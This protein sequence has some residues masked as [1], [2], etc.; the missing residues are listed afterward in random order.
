MSLGTEF[1]V[2]STGNLYT[3]IDAFNSTLPDNGAL[4]PPGSRWTLPINLANA[5]GAQ[6]YKGI[7]APLQVAYV[8]YGSATNPNFLASPGLVYW[9]D[10]SFTTVSG[11]VADGAFSTNGVAGWILVNTT[12]YPGSYTGATLATLVNNSFSTSTT[13]YSGG[14]YVFI[15]TGGYIPGAT[16]VASVAAGDYLIGGGTSF[17][18]ARMTAGTAPTNTVAGMAVT[19]VA[20]GL[21]DVLVK[22]FGPYQFTQ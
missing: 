14:S 16:S 11:A 1:P 21:S 3:A 13:P 5:I 18:P 12:N 9:V 4:N 8:L 17:T 19:A 2:I 10:K 15:V 7:G 22:N 6:P 20:G